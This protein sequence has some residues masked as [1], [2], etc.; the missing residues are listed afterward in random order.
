MIKF[1]ILLSTLRVAFPMQRLRMA[2]GR[3]GLSKNWYY[4]KCP[5]QVIFMLTQVQQTA[6][7]TKIQHIFHNPDGKDAKDIVPYPHNPMYNE[8]DFAR[9]DQMSGRDRINQLRDILTDEEVC[10][11]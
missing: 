6:L 11:L 4:N 2:S 3:I 7:Q 8:K 9:Y 5:E 10:M 1:R